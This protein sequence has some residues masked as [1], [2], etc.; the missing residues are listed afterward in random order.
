VRTF[1]RTTVVREPSS[2]DLRRKQVARRLSSN[3]YTQENSMKKVYAIVVGLLLVAAPA[4]AA[5]VDG[6]WTGTV[7]TPMGDLPVQY[8]FKAD[9]ATLT[10]TT[11]GFDG[12]SVPIKN[13]KVDGNKISFTVTFDFGGMSL[14][15]SYTGVVS[16]SEI[17]MTGDFMGMPFEFTVKKA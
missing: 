12:G 11:L 13:G 7:S 16:A 2:D 5:D 17:K 1:Q 8:E 14:D 4:F 15:L 9:G 6:K 10:G 3:D